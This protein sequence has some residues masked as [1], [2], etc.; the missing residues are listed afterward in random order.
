M[1]VTPS[2]SLVPVVRRSR[3]WRR[4][5]DRS[6]KLPRQRA[7][8]GEGRMGDMPS[9]LAGR[10]WRHS[11]GR[12]MAMTGSR[13]WVRGRVGQSGWRHESMGTWVVG[14]WL[15]WMRIHRAM[16]GELVVMVVMIVTVVRCVVVD[17]CWSKSSIEYGTASREV[18]VVVDGLRWDIPF[19]LR[20]IVIVVSVVSRQVG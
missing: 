5:K 16:P 10:I 1:R 7:S 15:V 20:R 4:V 19:P 14:V 6:S 9:S 3:Q 13:S 2:K 8:P 17:M 11:D 12:S 18:W